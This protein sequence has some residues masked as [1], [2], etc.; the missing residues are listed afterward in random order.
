[1]GLTLRAKSVG[2]NMKGEKGI[3]HEWLSQLAPARNLRRYRGHME[4]GVLALQPRDLR[5]ACRKQSESQIDRQVPELC[6]VH[7]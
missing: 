4:P 2:D 6:H 5:M 1:M 7:I 3:R